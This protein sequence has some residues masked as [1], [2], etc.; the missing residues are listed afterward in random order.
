MRQRSR[1]ILATGLSGALAFT[2][3]G[4]SASPDSTPSADGTTEDP[5]SV[6]GSITV[7]THR[8]DLIDNGTFSGYVTQFQ[9]EYPDVSVEF[10]GITAYED[11]VPIRLSSGEF[12]DVLTIP[13][14][15]RPDQFEQFFEPFGDQADLEGDYLFLNQVS[16]DGVAY[17]LAQGGNATGVVYNRRVLEDAGVAELPTSVEDFMSALAAIN[18][19]TDAVPLYTNY[20]D[21]WPLG[22]LQ[23]NIGVSLGNVD[24]RNDMVASDT[25]WVDGS[26]IYY[27]DSLLY[28]AV[29]AGYTEDDPLTTNWEA[30]K[31]MIGSGEVGMMVLGSWAISQMQAAAEDAGFS[32]DDIGFLPYP[33]ATDGASYA[34]V[35]G[36]Y[37]FGINKGSQNKDAARAWVDWFISS[38]PYAADEGFISSLK[39][40]PL[41]ANLSDLTDLGTEII[42]LVPEV[43]EG[44]FA[45]IDSESEIAIT[46]GGYRQRLVDIARGAANGDKANYFAELNDK[47][48]AA[49]ASVTG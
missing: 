48:A 19:N 23:R 45:R 31:V 4:C 40:E 33:S 38:S 22:D 43:E 27:V 13:R 46:Q 47:W 39:S 6:S 29:E 41:P 5:A 21:G 37:Y 18:D 20:K 26:D 49:R 1:S 8:T 28:D 34:L 30:S 16:S 15:V 14:S 3:I 35:E 44:L 10:E 25:P 42:E 24:A 2:M 32:A 12:G 11:E 9:E 17:G 7:L 36:D